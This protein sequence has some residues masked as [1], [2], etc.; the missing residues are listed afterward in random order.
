MTTAPVADRLEA[1]HRV[2][3]Y[4]LF[5]RFLSDSNGLIVSDAGHHLELWDWLWDIEKGQRPRPF[6]AV[7][8]RGGAKSTNAEIG[9]VAL[10][11]RRS[12]AY[13]LYVCDVQGRADGHVATIAGMLESPAIAAFYPELS[14]RSLSKYGQ[15]RGW[16]RNR[17]RTESGFTIDA[18]G[19]D[20]A[21]RGIKL[22]EHRPDMIILD[23]IDDTH[24]SPH[25]T[26]KK[27]RTITRSVLPAGSDDAAVLAIQNVIHPNSIFARLANLHEDKP[28]WLV[29][30]I[31]SGP[32]P[33][34]EDLTY[35]F[36]GDRYEITGGTPS[37]EG[38]D[39]ARCQA[40]IDDIG[41]SAF[42]EEGQHE[43]DAPPGGMYDH[44]DFPAMRVADHPELVKVAVWVDPAVSDTDS[45]DSHAIQADGIA[46][47]GTIYRLY[48]WERRAS[49]LQA[50]T[51]AITKAAELGA[52]YVG[53]ETD[54]GGDT[55]DSVFREA[56]NDAAA[57]RPDI[58][59]Q[60][61]RLTMRSEKAGAGRG[62]KAER[63]AR[64]LADYEKPGMRIRHVVGSH[65]QLE[66]ALRRFPRTK[67]LDLADAAY[68]SWQDLR[69]TAVVAGSK[70]EDD[71]AIRQAVTAERRS[72]IWND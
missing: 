56:R 45:S 42:L 28:D 29:D 34:I 67:P 37:W 13:I 66:S 17:L 3:R 2:W 6:V 68:W 71:A 36:N 9:A 20:V 22:D 64:M 33:A 7:W 57:A 49:P 5:E 62:S 30:R 50:I 19:L 16:R 27:L 4:A 11:A 1:N 65:R 21:V 69:E 10:G 58:A 54:Q 23:D 47:D 31:V 12:R 41:I 38:Q 44:L 70:H 43:V 48:S 35:R 14:R 51:K 53:I 72:R 15:S 59:G 55:W 18:L 24:D 60:I 25:V 8:P 39:L 52:T 32:I 26:A 46:E 63:S 40:L 61:R